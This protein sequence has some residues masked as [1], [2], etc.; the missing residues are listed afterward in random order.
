MRKPSAALIV[1]T[2]ALV[3][4]T[5]GTS[6]AATHYVI[7]SPKQVKPGTITLSALS[8]GARKA[9][10]GERGERG[11]A[12]A[13]GPQGPVGAAGIPGLSATKLWAQ[14]GSD[15]SVNVSTPGVTARL[16]VS[17]GTYAVNFGVDITR[18]AATA[19]QGSIPPFAT[20]VSATAGIAGAALV[21]LQG[22]GAELAPGFPTVST[23]LVET[24][25]GTAGGT[26]A[27]SAFTIAVLCG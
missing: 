24:T 10:R 27:P 1:A 17:P 2:A 9:L 6:V 5:I 18:C 4:S 11:R 8:K 16:G 14:I 12:G 25:N 19:T 21:F 13:S 3:M 26:A 20:P 7:T 15:A 23:V 22:A